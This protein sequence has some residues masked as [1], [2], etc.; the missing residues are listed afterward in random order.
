MGKLIQRALKLKYSHTPGMYQECPDK[1]LGD[2]GLEGFATDGTAY[3]CYAAR[4]PLSEAAL[5]ERQKRKIQTDIRKFRKQERL[6][7]ILGT[8][9][10][11]IWNL[12][13]PR[14][15]STPLIEYANE[16]AAQVRKAAAKAALR[17]GPP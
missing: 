14:F 4:E 15:G 12:V 16:K 8:T 7:K 2:A 17:S 6:K 13:V 9:K 10:I 5:H 11:T 1:Y 3:Q